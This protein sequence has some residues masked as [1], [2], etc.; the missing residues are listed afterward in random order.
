MSNQFFFS[1]IL[2]ELVADCNL[3]FVNVKLVG[4]N[5]SK[6]GYTIL[7]GKNDSVKLKHKDVLEL[8]E[9][10][11]AYTVEF[12]PVPVY[13]TEVSPKK[14]EMVGKQTTLNLFLKKR[15]ST[16]DEDEPNDPSDKTE[17][18][19]QKTEKSWLEV[20]G[21]KLIVFTSDSVQ[22]KSKV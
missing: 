4:A 12:D 17:A 21:G 10:Q 13:E 9:N 22:H 5:A 8:L 2:V 7:K 19:K 14:S 16:D 1:R 11:Y 15:K 3:G 18:K 6:A 20:D